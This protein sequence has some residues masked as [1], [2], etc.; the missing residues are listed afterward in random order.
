LVDSAADTIIKLS[1]VN[2]M[3][4]N[5]KDEAFDEKGKYQTGVDVARGGDDDT[6]FY[7]RK[8]L[9]VIDSKVIATP[10]LPPKAILVH[11]ADELCTFIGHD[12]EEEVLIDDTG[13][14]GGLTDVMQSKGYNIKPI[15]FGAKAKDENKYVNTISEI[16]YE[17][18]AKVHEISCANDTRLQRELVNRKGKLDKKGRRVVESKDD[19][20]KRGFPSPDKADAFLLAFYEPKSDKAVFLFTDKPVY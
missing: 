8:G 15:N 20:K 3:F 2:R 19:Y 11:L 14:G 16:W 1:Q 17:V 13:V 10:D 6:V 9:K 18:A 5:A 12:K 4:D 7:R